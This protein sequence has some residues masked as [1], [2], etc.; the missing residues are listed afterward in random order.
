[1]DKQNMNSKISVIEQIDDIQKWLGFTYL[2]IAKLFDVDR[3]IIYT[4]ISDGLN[5]FDAKNEKHLNEIHSFCDIWKDKKLGPMHSLGFHHPQRTS[6]I[7][8]LSEEKLDNIAIE[9]LLDQIATEQLA[10]KLARTKRRLRLMRAGFGD[11]D[12]YTARAKRR[13]KMKNHRSIS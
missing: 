3:S 13:E 10:R 9:T 12:G 1:M 5:L 11:V 6:L 8:C 7:K 2:E 4:M